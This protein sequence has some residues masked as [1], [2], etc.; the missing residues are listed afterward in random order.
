M[1]RE[2]QLGYIGHL[3]RQRYQLP[4][5]G[6][7]QYHDGVVHAR[8]AIRGTELHRRHG[9]VMHRRD[10]LR[11]VVQRSDMQLIGDG[12]LP[13]LGA[14]QYDHRVLHTCGAIRGTKLHNRHGG[15]VH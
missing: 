12:R 2:L 15:V 7:G 9:G 6:A 1:H 11:F 8:G 3:E 10:C 14:S 13:V 5:L 4:V